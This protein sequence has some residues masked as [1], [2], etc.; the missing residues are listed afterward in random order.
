MLFIKQAVEPLLSGMF[1]KLF[2]II[3]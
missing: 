3:M 1:L 2:S